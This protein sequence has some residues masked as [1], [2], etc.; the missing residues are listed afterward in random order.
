MGMRFKKVRKVLIFASLL[1]DIIAEEPCGEE[2]D[3]CLSS[4]CALLLIVVRIPHFLLLLLAYSSRL[5]LSPIPLAYS[6][7]SFSSRFSSCSTSRPHF[8]RNIQLIFLKSRNDIIHKTSL[9]PVDHV[10]N[11][12]WD[13]PSVDLIKLD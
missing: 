13:F 9:R 12:V 4:Y 11:L 3:G 2:G 7:R 1:S 8:C 6:S 5:F 10:A